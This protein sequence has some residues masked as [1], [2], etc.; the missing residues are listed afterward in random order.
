MVDNIVIS[1]FEGTGYWAYR[2]DHLIIYVN[3]KSLCS[4]LEIHVTLYVNYISITFF[5]FTKHSQVEVNVP[6]GM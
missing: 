6:V 5:M 1:L 3:V 4:P 2:G